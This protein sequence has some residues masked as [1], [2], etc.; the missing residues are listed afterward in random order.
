[1][2]K[3]RIVFWSV[4]ASII[5]IIAIVITVDC[6]KNPLN[7]STYPLIKVSKDDITEVQ[8]LHYGKTAIISDP[9]TV[10]SLVG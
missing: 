5:V 2:K 7:G 6:Y 9:E 3:K 8:I 4:L 1:M 10:E